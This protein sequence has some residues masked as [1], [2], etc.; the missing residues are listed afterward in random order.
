[1]I[2]EIDELVFIEAGMQGQV[3]QSREALCL[4]LGQTGNRRWIENSV[5]ND[6]QP[7]RTLGNK[8][9]A[10]REE[11]HT[12]RLIETFGDEQADLMLNACIEDDGSG[13]KRR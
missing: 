3:H 5:A 2:G 9:G 13:R 4:H 7:S 1:M 6:A 11:R 12:P 8:D 10:V